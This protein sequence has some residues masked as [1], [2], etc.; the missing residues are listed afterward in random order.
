[1]EITFRLP[2]E[3]KLPDFYEREEPEQVALALR[4]GAEA[5]EQLY[6]KTAAAIRE[7][8]HEQTTKELEAEFH[9]REE[10]RE[11]EIQ[12]LEES[13][14]R[15]R[16]QNSFLENMNST[17]Q[18]SMI[19]KAE[20]LAATRLKDKEDQIAS[21]NAMLRKSQDD[22]AM[23][24][25]R[26]G[27]SVYKNTSNSSIKGKSGEFMVEEMLKLSLDCEVYKT[28]N[29]AYSGDHHIIRG[30]GKYKYIVDAKN[31]SRMVSQAEVDK[32]HRDLRV[33]AD[34]VGAI[35]ISLN[36]GIVG[37]SRA[38]DIDIEFNEH[39]K[40]IVYIGNLQRREEVNVL[41]A[42]LRPFFEV[43]ERLSDLRHE[44]GG[45]VHEEHEKLQYRAHLVSTLL[46]NHMETVLKAKNTFTLNKKKLEAIYNDQYAYL[47][48]MEGQVKNTL[49][50]VLG[51]AEQT[52]HAIQDDTMPLPSS[53][54]KKTNR[55]ELSEKEAK[56]VDWME[57]LFEF[58]DGSEVELK[59]FLE[60][61]AADGFSE[62][63]TRAMREKIFTEE[64]WPKQGRK[65]RGLLLKQEV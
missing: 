51:D 36:Q 17:M 61:A 58:Q 5:V 42:S 28:S 18:T 19:E 63:D 27:E 39:G 41:F 49:A 50:V 26:L 20:A 10:K 38:G 14:R 59:S 4:L 3:F 48:Q 65:L 24:M 43:V 32:L 6:K 16:E 25:D 62:K 60:K 45:Q 64:A 13:V 47:L 52:R 23:K 29:E 53:V 15:L 54:F 44:E 21:L 2:S 55:T 46:R 30:K 34:A 12:K 56:F 8:T 57:K 35:M 9:E 1:M 33:N 40:P 22:L 7:E 11:K 37:H 31:Y